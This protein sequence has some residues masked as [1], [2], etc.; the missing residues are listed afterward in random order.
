M[1]G[2]KEPIAVY[3]ITLVRLGVK[4]ID[5]RNV[6]HVPGIKSPLYPLIQH[7]KLP[8]CGYIGNNKIAHIRGQTDKKLTST[9]VIWTFLS[10]ELTDIF[11]KYGSLLFFKKTKKT[12]ISILV[13]N[14]D[15]NTTP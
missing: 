14:N 12:Q 4:V 3:G 6:F 9:L 5:K 13:A 10:F 1:N 15:T 2:D 11:L 8:D 7:R